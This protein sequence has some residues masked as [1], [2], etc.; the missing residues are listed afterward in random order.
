[1]TV[2]HLSPDAS[3]P[4]VFSPSCE[5]LHALTLFLRYFN[6]HADKRSNAGKHVDRLSVVELIVPTV[7]QG[8]QANCSPLHVRTKLLGQLGTWEQGKP[9]PTPA[10]AQPSPPN[11][12]L[13]S[14]S[15]TGNS[16]CNKQLD[17]CAHLHRKRRW[18]SRDPL[19][20]WPGCRP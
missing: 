18:Q 17:G 5:C 1:M 4:G 16:P 8:L 15:C 9:P 11:P 14:H 6:K 10:P 13:S 19:G 7:Q 2:C 20:V 12:L 3:L